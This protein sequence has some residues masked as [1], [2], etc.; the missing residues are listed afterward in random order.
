MNSKVAVST[1]HE[2]LLEGI[3]SLRT[4]LR[5]IHY[6]NS[7]PVDTG[8]DT[9]GILGEINCR[10]AFLMIANSLEAG[11][12]SLILSLNRDKDFYD[13]IEK[14]N[15]MLKFQIFCELSGKRLDKGNAICANIKDIIY[16]RNEFVHPKP[17]L[18]DYKIDEASSKINYNIKRTKVKQY[19]HYFSEV[20]PEHVL[21]AL[22]DTLQFV[23][24]I[25]FDICKFGL[26]EG[27]LR[28]GL[29]SYGSTADLDIIEVEQQRK[30]DKRSF[31]IPN[32]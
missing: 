16:C 6:A 14:F 5:L 25:C 13:E 29:N 2:Y 32:K 4:G 24:W 20:K 30:F 3:L 19:P 27:A 7:L 17:R 10:Y 1:Y 11:A 9:S 31:G 23:S 18:V 21:T 8:S 12:N 28:V 15:T 22:Q 26:Q